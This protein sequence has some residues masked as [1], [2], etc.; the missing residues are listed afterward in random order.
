MDLQHE[1]ATF[2]GMSFSRKTKIFLG[3]TYAG[4]IVR[5]QL[6][7]GNPGVHAGMVMNSF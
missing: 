1:F 2:I 3:K 4:S 7:A 6:S 5:K